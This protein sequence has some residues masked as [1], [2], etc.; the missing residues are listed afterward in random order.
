M[1]HKL[2]KYNKNNILGWSETDFRDVQCQLINTKIMA[3]NPLTPK[4]MRFYLSEADDW[5]KEKL[6]LTED[7]LYKLEIESYKKRIKELKK[8]KR[9]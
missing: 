3:G 4:E 1:N 2:T 9:G 8:Q 7:I 5:H 6:G